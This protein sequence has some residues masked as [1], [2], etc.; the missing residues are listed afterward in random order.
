M[1]AVEYLVFID[2]K[3]VKCKDEKSFR[4][5][6]QSDPDI[7]IKD[8]K[9]HFKNTFKVNFSIQSG[10]IGETE[11]VYFHL[12]FSVNNEAHIDNLIELLRSVKSVFSIMTTSPQVLYDGIS[13]YYAE[14]TYPIIYHIENLVRK[15]ITKFML[16]NVDINWTNEKVPDDVRSSINVENKDTTYLHNVD[17]IQLK[18]F[19]FSEKYSVSKDKLIKKIKEINKS[20][21]IDLEELKNLIPTSNWDRYFSKEIN[22]SKEKLV[23]KWTDLYDLRCKIAHNKTF[24]KSDFTKVTNLTDE[25]NPIFQKAIQNLDSIDVSEND[26]VNLEEEVAGN[27]NPVLGEF[28]SQWR[29][30]EITTKIVVTRLI[31]NKEIKK[32]VKGR[33]FVKDII[34]LKNIDIISNENYIEVKKLRQLRNQIV[35][36]SEEVSFSE[37]ALQTLRVVKLRNIIKS[38][39]KED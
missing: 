30:L 6:L 5:L 9:I 23:K 31:D 34:L 29:K 26:R 38:S 28:I 17:F 11:Q 20:S 2:S 18:N 25:L 36:F 39:N 15:L 19:L 7:I 1:I 35:H 37:L 3:N 32:D 21:D 4:H 22:I 16:V 10:K 24:S 14:K 27:F 8:S 13:Q 33:S 12:M